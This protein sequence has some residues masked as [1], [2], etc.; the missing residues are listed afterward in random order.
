ML[1]RSQTISRAVRV[2]GECCLMAGLAANY[3]R[4]Q[5]ANKYQVKAAFLYNFGRFVDWPA[6]SSTDPF[7]IGILGDDPFHG[8]LEAT[9]KDKTIDGRQVLVNR[10]VSI[11]AARNC[12]VLF[13][14]PSESQK[15]PSILNSL[16]GSP[17]LTVGETT[18]FAR[19]GGVINFRIEDYRVRFEIN[20][21]A[22]E[23][24]GL[25]ISSK[26]LSLARIV[27]EP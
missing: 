17:V 5:A 11:D 23:R 20:V 13:I 16:K 27:K 14:S 12:Q 1:L 2:L 3:A 9:V 4:G 8:A 10:V 26:L 19:L 7:V 24:A 6:N 18:G 25:K 22:A 15:L 21:D